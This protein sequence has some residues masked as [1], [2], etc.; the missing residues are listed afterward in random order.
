[1]RVLTTLK[2]PK[3]AVDESVG[4]ESARSEPHDPL[5][6]SVLQ[7]GQAAGSFI[8]YWG[9]KAIHG[10]IWTVLALHI[11]PLSQTEICELLGVS[12]S[13]VSTA[14]AELV[15]FGLVRPVDG[16]RNA[17]Y[18]AII[19][20]WPAVA[21]VR[22][23]REW[24]LLESARVALEAA[25]EEVEIAATGRGA[26]VWNLDRLKMLQ[27]MTEMA[28]SLVKLLMGLRLPRTP[29]GFGGWLGMAGKVVSRF[30]GG[31]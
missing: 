15:E 14:M 20:I 1:M 18:E 30:R 27:G 24:M 9:F 17:P 25:I 31:R 23:S 2:S 21:E 6:R 3:A 10:R 22:R 4:V 8:E 29:E 12:R 19:D 11:E 13:A 28:Q 26:A 5:A 16:H 7:V